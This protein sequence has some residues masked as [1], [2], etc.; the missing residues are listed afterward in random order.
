M[1]VR[2]ISLLQQVWDCYKA[3]FYGDIGRIFE[4]LEEHRHSREGGDPDCIRTRKVL[5]LMFRIHAVVK[6]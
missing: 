6:L 3:W 5:W 4:E 2:P 1:A